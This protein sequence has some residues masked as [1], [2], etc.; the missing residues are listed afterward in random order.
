MT[1][2]VYDTLAD[3]FARHRGVHPGVLR[4]LVSQSGAT[5][6]AR[7]LEVGCGTGNYLAAIHATGRCECRGVDPSSAM[8]RHARQRAPGVRWD[9]GSAERHPLRLPSD[10]CNGAFNRRSTYNRI[11]RIMPGLQRPPIDETA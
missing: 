3:E 6:A 11:R 1:P 7:V 5:G 10:G 4:E 2:A 8:F 9:E